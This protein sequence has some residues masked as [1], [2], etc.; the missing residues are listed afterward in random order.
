MDADLWYLKRRAEDGDKAAQLTLGKRYL[1]GDKYVS[2]DLDI[3]ARLLT[4]AKRQGCEEAEK[5]LIQMAGRI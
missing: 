4:A 1:F 3:A 2:K 5:L